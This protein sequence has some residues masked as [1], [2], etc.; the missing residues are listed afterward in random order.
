[1]TVPLPSYRDRLADRIMRHLWRHVPRCRDL[2][3]IARD[4]WE[5]VYEC[6][7]SP[8]VLDVPLKD[9]LGLGPTALPCDPTG[10]H[11][12][13]DTLVALRAGR[14]AGYAGSPLEAYYT[15]W[16]PATAG[17][18]LGL[19]HVLPWASLPPLACA[20]PWDSL[21]PATHLR[22]WTDICQRDYRMN[23]FALTI[24]AGW[25]GWGPLTAAA[26]EAEFL[27]LQRALVSI[28]S[29]GYR[30][31]GAHDGDITAQ[32][33]CD[34]RGRLRFLLGPGQHRIAALAALGADHVPVRID[35][36]F[37]RR[38]DAPHWPNVRR[39]HYSP[40]QALQVFDRIFA[41]RPPWQGTGPVTLPRLSGAAG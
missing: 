40:D 14:I 5:A 18:V 34:A 12:F 4:A 33:L 8:F 3:G 28:G 21:D 17:A 16:Q 39:G 38:E 24:Q 9:C 25:K 19:P 26:G 6:P 22:F 23:G 20:L 10:G 27:R 37:I 15:R 11:P 30:R 31:H 7:D 1:M 32:A 41:G 13:I 2:R 29:R 36:H 35:P